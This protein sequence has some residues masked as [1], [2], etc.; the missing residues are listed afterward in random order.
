MSLQ[1][2]AFSLQRLLAIAALVLLPVS[3]RAQSPNQNEEME[4]LRMA[5][6][7]EA[8]GDVAGA[9]AILVEM[10]NRRP[11]SLSALL[12]V[13]RLLRVQG[14]D[15]EALVFIERFLEIDPRSPI[16]H[17]LALRA[18]STMDRV[19]DLL[20]AE[21]RWIEAT[22]GVETPY[23][24]AARVWEARD[25]FERALRVL[26]EGRQRIGRDALA[27]EIGNVH[28][29]KG[30][31]RD[32]IEEWSAAI[33]NEG[34][35]F[36]LVQRRLASLPD[37]GAAIVPGLIARLRQ[38]P[39]TTARLRS[40]LTLAIGAG[41]EE[42]G[43]QLAQQ[44]YSLLQHASRPEFLLSTGRDADASR[45]PRLAYWAYRA[46]LQQMPNGEESDALRRRV[47]ELA[48]AVGDSA[49]A[50]QAAVEMEAAAEPGTVLA[51]QAAARRI[52]LS[53][54]PESL[55]ESIE[56]F[57]AFKTE[58]GDV[59][60]VDRLAAVIGGLLLRAGRTDDAAAIV[61]G[62]RGGAAAH[63]R[64]RVALLQGDPAAARTAFQSA[65]TTLVGRQATEVIAFATLLA[66]ATPAG[67][68]RLG[69]ALG[70]LDN[71][72][73]EAA[74]DALTEPSLELRPDERA[75]L[76]DLAAR[77]ADAEGL[78]VRAESARRT[79]IDEHPRASEAASALLGLARALAERPDGA[80]EARALL[81]RL[82]LDHPRSALVPQARRLL[83]EVTQRVP[84]S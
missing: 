53:A 30:D 16:G 38:T 27:W 11:G 14:R 17:Q 74:L 46:L 20:R 70:H 31:T 4:R 43:M 19:D 45:Q 36:H 26:R 12:S 54:T 13:D 71:G 24:E 23:R 76:L 7:A 37:G 59:P 34:E 42:Q 25:D 35:R 32:A 40:A 9:E 78:G 21:R 28:A 1:L 47:G 77:I 84:T 66:R 18:L 48:L 83:A 50:R 64:A 67:A 75:G 33:G 80:E 22:P 56:A 82:I 29:L 39:T 41:L 60:E 15:E 44:V 81:E 5:Q 69:A 52:E 2:S 10:L 63:V 58:H 65:A 3:A 79:L 61:E 68:R 51:R 55:D 72:A 6:Q 73:A 62:G 8:A 49:T 57:R